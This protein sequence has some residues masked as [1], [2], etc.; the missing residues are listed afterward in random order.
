MSLFEISV[1]KFGIPLIVMSPL[2]PEHLYNIN[3]DNQMMV[4][5]MPSSESLALATS[6]LVKHDTYLNIFVYSDAHDA[7]PYL[8]PRNDLCFM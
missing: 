4:N 3:I 5:Y 1:T 8:K 6:A 2:Y 7:L